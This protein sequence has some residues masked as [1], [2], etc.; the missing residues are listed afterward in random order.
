MYIAPG[1][2]DK[3][4]IAQTQKDLDVIHDIAP[5]GMI[6]LAKTNPT[7]KGWF[8]SFPWAHPDPTLPAVIY[9]N[10]KPGLKN[11]RRALGADPGDRYRAR[12]HGLL[13]RR[14]DDLG[15]PRSADRVVPQ[16]LLRPAGAVAEGL[17][18][19]CRWP[20]GQSMGCEAATR[21]AAEAKKTLGDVVP[22]DPAEIRKSIGMGWW[23]YDVKTAEQLD[24]A[25]RHEER[26]RRQVAAAGRH[27]FKIALLAEGE[28]RPVMNRGADMIVQ[29]WK[30]FG[31]D[32]TL[33]VR[34]NTSRAKMTALGEYG[35][36][37]RLDDRDLGRSPRPVLLPRVLAFVAVQADLASGLLAATGCAGRTPSSTGS[38]SP[39]RRS[40]S[41][42]PRA[43]TWASQ[44][45]K[46]AAQEMPITPIMSYNVFS[47]CDETYWTG[48]PTAENPYTDPVANWANTRYMYV[49]IKSIKA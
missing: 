10:E 29:C 43:S 25:G 17:H 49:K 15:H 2:S 37:V 9:N 16:V 27:P 1:P 21:I 34:D 3:K 41:T 45:V 4:V 8:K 39:S 33:D 28:T 42:I 36:R 14:R 35:C 6:T 26:R 30:E 40:T 31:V 38:S 47:V 20:A 48:F 46:L 44:F 32:A 22:T 13:P 18:P 19:R 7:S 11:K 23:K 12:G 24:A 5:E